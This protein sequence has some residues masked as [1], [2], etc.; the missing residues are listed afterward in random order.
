M[1]TGSLNNSPSTRCSYSNDGITWINNTMPASA[2][3]NFPVW[4]G[5]IFFVMDSDTVGASSSDG[6]TWK[7]YA[8][9][10]P[11]SGTGW[12]NIGNSG[13]VIILTRSIAI[14]NLFESAW[15]DNGG[16]S[17]HLVTTAL[18]Y[19]N[20][21]GA[22]N[23]IGADG[24]GKV[25]VVSSD[26]ATVSLNNGA[27]WTRYTM[28]GTTSWYS[29][30]YGNGTWVA[31]SA[32]GASGS[33]IATSPDGIFWTNRGAS[34]ISAIPKLFFNGSQFSMVGLSGSSQSFSTSSD[35]ITWTVAV[36]T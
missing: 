1:A 33:I 34:P 24:T 22:V 26:G 29:V 16:A 23:N 30:V 11:S 32:G 10:T 7:L 36:S 3:W 5:N 28:V 20:P 25:V 31:A 14:G 19:L 15:S 8:L 4:N 2:K 6:I 35:G 21:S 13:S 18:S 17:W 9:P 27:S 12:A